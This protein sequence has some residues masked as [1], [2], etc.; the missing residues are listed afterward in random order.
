MSN[1]LAFADAVWHRVIQ[2]VQEAMLS[3]VDCADILRQVRVEVSNVDPNVLVLTP[4]YL[5]QVKEMHQKMVQEARDL[6]ARSPAG[7]R[8][9]IT[10]D[11]GTGSDGGRN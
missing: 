8:F 2:I 3:G 5:Q 9:L 4:A 6:Q 10:G 7:P 11:D 1:D